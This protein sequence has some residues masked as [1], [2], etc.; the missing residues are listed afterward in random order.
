MT[1]DALAAN[2]AVRDGSVPW[3]ALHSVVK[4]A[5]TAGTRCVLLLSLSSNTFVA[6]RRR[7]VISSLKSW[8]ATHTV[9]GLL[10]FGECRF[11]WR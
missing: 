5:P 3:Q 6:N 9:K 2:V 4:G 1:Q 7:G 8:V 10:V 11:V